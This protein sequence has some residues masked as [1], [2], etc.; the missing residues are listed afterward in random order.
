MSEVDL[1]AEKPIKINCGFYSAGGT[2]CTMTEIKRE[3][4]P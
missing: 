3:N 1:Y 4:G 2:L